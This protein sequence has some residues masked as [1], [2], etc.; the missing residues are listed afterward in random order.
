MFESK[1]DET[2]RRAGYLRA[3]AFK[4][5]EAEPEYNPREQDQSKT[6]GP[7]PHATDKKSQFRVEEPV[8]IQLTR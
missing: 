8:H 2:R 5:P 1:R 3:A 4:P 7:D 6:D